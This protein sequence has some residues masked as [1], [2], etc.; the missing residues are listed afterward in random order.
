MKIPKYIIWI[1]AATIILFLLYLA[2]IYLPSSLNKENK[3]F[4]V[5]KGDSVSEIAQNLKEQGLIRNVLLFKGYVWITGHSANLKSGRYV[6]NPRISLANITRMISV[7]D[8]QGLEITIIEGWDKYDIGDY[9]QGKDIVIKKDFLKALKTSFDLEILNDKPNDVDSDG[10]LFPDTYKLG[11]DF[12][13]QAIIKK[14]VLNLDKK[15]DSSLREEIIKQGETIFEIITMASLIEK[16]VIVPNDRAIVSGILWKRLES[17]MPLQVDATI[18]YIT[19]QKGIDIKQ[20]DLALD[21]EYNTYRY[22]GLPKG[23]ICNP[24]LDA[25]TAAIYPKKTSYWYYLSKPDGITIFSKTLKEHN[26][27]RA[28]YLK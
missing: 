27:A 2:Q 18:N 13:A 9:L 11:D 14:A 7:G 3:A 19:G 1:I 6:F 15:L 12:S 23:P 5:Q 4:L 16:E 28:K 26:I 21:S 22:L 24:G 8:T 25:I 20:E 17:K 10:Y